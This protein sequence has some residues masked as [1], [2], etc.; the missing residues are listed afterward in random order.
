MNDPKQSAIVVI[1]QRLHQDDVSGTILSGDDSERWTHLMIPMRYD[2]QRHCSTS[3]G[4]NDP[5][6]LD[7]DGNP[8]VVDGMPVSAEAAVELN[9]CQNELMWPERFG[10]KEVAAIEAGLGPYMASGRLQQSPQPKG[11]GIFKS[12]WWQ[13]WEGTHF[14]IVDLVIASLDSAF[15]EKQENDPSALTVWGVF[16][17]PELGKTRVILIDAWRKHLQM[18]GSTTPRLDHEI[19]QLGDDAKIRRYKDTLWAKRVG[20]AWGL[21]EWTVHSMR[22]WGASILLVEGKAS[23]LT[24]HQELRRLHSD[25][26]WSVQLINP[27]GD[28]IVRALAAQPT[29]AQGLIYAPVKDWSQMVIDEMEV[30]PKGPI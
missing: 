23:G 21:V 7:D 8:L 20:K 29:F 28:K 26:G 16:R 11:G 27:K 4:W 17:H 1:M 19:L 22:K 18:H 12:E 2:P 25:E 10:E 5:R 15:T 24:V 30:F 13:V 6:G 9:E 14:P 3:L